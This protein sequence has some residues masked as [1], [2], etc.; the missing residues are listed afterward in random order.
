MVIDKKWYALSLVRG[1]CCLNNPLITPFIPLL[2]L[3]LCSHWIKE[4]LGLYKLPWDSFL[5]NL[6]F[7]EA[8][9]KT[10]YEPYNTIQR[11]LEKFCWVHSFPKQL[12][13]CHVTKTAIPYFFFRSRKICFNLFL[14]KTYF[15]FLGLPP[16]AP[17]RSFENNAISI[18]FFI[19]SHLH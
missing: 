1:L 6:I 16:P 14:P 11:M 13:I 7:L 5:S 4:V 17:C 18:L 12:P 15:V 19:L 2:P 8:L 3:I 9:K 10:P